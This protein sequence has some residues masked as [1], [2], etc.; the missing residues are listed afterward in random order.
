MKNPVLS[1]PDAFTSADT[2][3]GTQA[4]GGYAQPQGSFGGSPYGAPTG[5]AAPQQGGYASGYGQSYVGSA[6]G[7]GAAPQVSQ[8]GFDQ[9]P[10]AT[11][12]SQYMT[13]DGVI[14]KTVA[15]LATVIAVGVVSI[16]LIPI[17]LWFPAMVVAGLATVVFPMVAAFRRSMGPVF[18]VVYGV[19]E[20]VFLG[21][22]SQIFEMYYPGI[23]MQAVLGTF[24]A[25]AVTLAAFHFG[26]FRANGKFSKILRLC[27]MGFAA[28]ALVSL[29]LSL[30]GINLG[31]YAGVT[32]P[33]G[34]LAWVWALAGV[35][36][37]VFSLV[38][39]FTYI[40][41][42]INRRAPAKQ[43]WVAAWGLAVTLV[44]LYT[45]LLRILSYVNRR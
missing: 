7:Y 28:V 41:N 25:A 4:P 36:L 3:Y 16:R 21:V 13:I 31:F 40:E 24:C 12:P 38:D 33:V 6:P 15:I 42:G 17:D 32:G 35:V 30:F 9:S 44:W 37:A 45:E 43:G 20:G 23:V 39:D 2:R 34:R 1:Q 8:P 27:V 14:A 26:G 29:V 11:G 18:A 5:Y 10:Y 22:V 19:L